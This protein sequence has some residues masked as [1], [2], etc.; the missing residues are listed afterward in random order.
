MIENISPSHSLLAWLKREVRPALGCTEPIAIAFAAATAAQHAEGNI[1]EIFGK[2]SKNLYKNADGVRLP[3]IS[4]HGVRLAAAIGAVGGNASLA[5]EL[6]RDVNPEHI[7]RAKKLIDENKVCIQTRDS[8]S[9]IYVEITV[10]TDIKRCRV[11]IEDNHT[12]ITHLSVDGVTGN[13][14]PQT[15]VGHRHSTTPPRFSIQEAVDF[16]QHVAYDDIAFMLEAVQL[17]SALSAEGQNTPYGLNVN[18]ALRLAGAEIFRQT[19]LKDR[20]VIDT[21]AASDARMGGAAMP[22]MTN[23]GSGNQGI[24]ATI[25]V[26]TLAK[27]LQRSEEELV[28]AVTLSHLVAISI[29]SRYARLSALCAASTAAMGAAAGMAWLLSK[30]YAI[31]SGAIKNM[32][33]DISGIICDGASATC[34]MKVSSTTESAVKSVLMA[35]QHWVANQHD[36]IVHED[37]EATIDALCRL[38]A[39]AMQHTDRQIIQIMSDKTF[40]KTHSL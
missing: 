26:V 25:P 39:S 19:T 13:L 29:H 20:I 35:K 27:H 36:G 6:L 30:D 23:F 10:V 14:A 7:T 34:A 33:G 32:I 2:I 21:V 37:V 28:R 9:L 31:I 15:R 5:L 38:A 12:Q 17:N 40:Q 11:V 16:I 22:A 3:N 24:A 4:G 1:V 18:G 8:D